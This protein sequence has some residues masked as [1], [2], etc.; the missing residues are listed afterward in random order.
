MSAHP[1]L[2]LRHAL[3]SFVPPWLSN[4]PA[5]PKSPAFTNGYRYLYAAAAM[6]DVFI[7][8]EVQGLRARFPGIG[9]PTALPLISQDRRI[10]RGLTEPDDDFALRLRGWLDSWRVAGNG[11]NM[12]AQLAPLFSPSTVPIL[13]LVTNTGIWLTLNTDGTVTR[14]VLNNWNW[15]GVTAD[16]W[17]RCWVII[18]SGDGY[19]WSAEDVWGTG[20]WGDGPGTWG[21][22]A[23]R[24]M[25]QTIEAVVQLWKAEVTLYPTTIIALDNAS[26]NPSSP[27][28]DGTWGK[29]YKLVGGVPVPSRLATARYFEGAR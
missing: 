29:F 10:I 13:R 27:E 1:N 15:D 9:T 17:A 12:L 8:V 22:T 24:E 26:F 20:T 7:E 11:Y 25:V 6:L 19:P 18:Y 5:T 3:R 14:Q 2:N 16:R 21:I 28:P 4:R 23:T